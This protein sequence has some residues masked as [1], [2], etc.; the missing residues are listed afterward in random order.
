MPKIITHSQK[1]AAKN[2]AKVK[3]NKIGIFR[4]TPIPNTMRQITGLPKSARLYMCAASKY[5]QFRVHLQGRYLKRSTKETDE[6]KAKRKAAIIYAAMLQNIHE[7]DAGTRRVSTRD[8]LQICANSL[9][10]K[11]RLLIANG[12]L[13][14][15][16]VKTETY[17]FNSHIKPF[18]SRYK[19]KDI[20]A[21]ALEAFKMH[22]AQKGLARA[23]QKNYV[24]IVSKILQEAVKKHYINIVPSMPRIRQDDSPRGYFDSNEYR[25]LWQTAK[26]NR[27]QE[28]KF[29]GENGKSYR[30]IKITDECKELILFMR[31]TFIRP[32]DIKVLKHGDVHIIS[33][34]DLKILELRHETTKRHSN[35]MASTPHAHQN[36]SVILERRKKIGFGKDTDYVFMP[37]IMNR[38]YA[39][40]ELA[41]Q[42]TAILQITGLK[43]DN[44]GNQ[45]T[46][47]SL[48]HTAIVTALRQGIPMQLIAS[49]ARTSMEMIDR[50][51]GSHINS[52]L[53]MGAHI[54]KTYKAQNDYYAERAKQKAAEKE[55]Q[56]KIAIAKEYLK[57]T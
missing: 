34:Y 7:D 45:R 30:K 52:A 9:F 1:K 22:L 32:T 33:K 26:K 42:F 49:N 28:Y 41:R 3:A 51:Y 47:Y 23:T 21:D 46:L 13:S 55:N 39:L 29:I 17:V 20:D 53:Q 54:F 50:F 12:E 40:K 16:K 15:N 35:Y 4:T 19:L 27:N 5:W 18:F 48:R 24:D 25:A 38:D 31:N 56:I 57:D 2:A 36:Y 8:T 44:K 14:K 43:T 37:H 6:K 11:Q 10:E